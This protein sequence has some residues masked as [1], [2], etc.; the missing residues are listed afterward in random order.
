V[1]KKSFSKVIQV[2]CIWYTAR[3]FVNSTI[4]C[5]HHN[6]KVTKKLNPRIWNAKTSK[7]RITIQF[8]TIY[9][10]FSSYRTEKTSY[11]SQIWNE[12]L[13]FISKFMRIRLLVPY[14]SSYYSLILSIEII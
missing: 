6:K 14:Q 13:P 10:N 2:W 5:T 9:F 3:T 8:I 11:S 4:Y 7:T 1:P 12:A